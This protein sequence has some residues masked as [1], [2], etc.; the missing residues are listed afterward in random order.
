MNRKQRCEKFTGVQDVCAAVVVYG[1][2]FGSGY[3]FVMVVSLLEIVSLSDDQIYKKICDN[4][5]T[6]LYGTGGKI[7]CY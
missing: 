2:R 1:G 6:F 3:F 4:F 5:Q 7:C